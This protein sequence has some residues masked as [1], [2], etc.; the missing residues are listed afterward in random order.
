LRGGLRNSPPG[1]GRAAPRCT[2]TSPSGG[3]GLL[4]WF[5][6]LLPKED[7][8]F[9]LFNGHA[10]VVLLGAHALREL[11]NGGA[12]VED[13]CKRIMQHE[14]EADDFARE[15]SLAVRRTFIT[16][17]DRGDIKDLS[18]LLDDAIDQMQKTAKAITLFEVDT[19]RPHMREM[20]DLIVEAAVQTVEAVNLLSSMAANANRINAIAVEI[21]RIEERADNVYDAGMKD[22]FLAH[23]T[24]DP[25]GYI[26]GA[27]IYDHLEK[28][29]D[30]F[31]DVANG[32]SGVLIEH[33]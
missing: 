2:I 25:M 8:F 32:I 31:E 33:L 22:L 11:L 17:F 10:A 24:S 4:K 26:V 7:R 18:G 3:R 6:A 23:R 13:A 30:R 19:F 28:V 16:P 27:E 5:H 21:T 14:N 15:V 29:V 12:A 9:E 1:V 20:G